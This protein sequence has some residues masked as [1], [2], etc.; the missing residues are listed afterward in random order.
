LDVSNGGPSR[1]SKGHADSFLAE[2]IDK[3][4]T[5]LGIV[6]ADCKERLHR[7]IGKDGYLRI[8]PISSKLEK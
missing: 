3:P 2:D 7:I 6:G 1:R 4:R 8:D 5:K